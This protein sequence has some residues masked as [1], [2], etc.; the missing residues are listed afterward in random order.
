MLGY[1]LTL[2]LRDRVA[3]NCRGGVDDGGGEGGSNRRLPRN[4]GLIHVRY[5]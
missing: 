5:L 2:Y 3:H 4:Q 1:V